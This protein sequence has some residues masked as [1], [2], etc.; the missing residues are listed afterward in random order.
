MLDQEST[1]GFQ[2][3][4]PV[5]ILLIT[6]N[7][8]SSNGQTCTLLFSRI[9]YPMLPMLERRSGDMALNATVAHRHLPPPMN[10][11]QRVCKIEQQAREPYP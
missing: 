3:S 4:E 8:L 7:D 2:S 1:V 10:A 6:L 9:A 11:T 5:C